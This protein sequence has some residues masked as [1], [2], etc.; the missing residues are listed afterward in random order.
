[1]SDSIPPKVRQQHAV[2]LQNNLL[3]T[4]FLKEMKDDCIATWVNGSNVAQR[5]EQWMRLQVV[6]DF[7]ARIQRAIDDGKMVTGR[8]DRAERARAAG[9]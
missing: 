7:E 2:G 1:M 6:R 5:E 3:L 9:R 4:A 8:E